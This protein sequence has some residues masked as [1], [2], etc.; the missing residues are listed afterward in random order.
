MSIT[1]W[2]KRV[3][4]CITSHFATTSIH[5]QFLRSNRCHFLDIYKKFSKNC[6]IRWWN[7]WTSRKILVKNFLKRRV[8]MC[9]LAQLVAKTLNFQSLGINRIQSADINKKLFENWWIRWR[10]C[11]TSHKR[12]LKN[13]LKKLS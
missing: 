12:S 7:C 3:K 8:K 2:T 13:F 6:W 4:I 9:I 5:S 10:N 11:W 1:F